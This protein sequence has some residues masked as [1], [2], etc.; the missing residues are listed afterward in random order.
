MVSDEERYAQVAR[1][2][3][4]VLN[5]LIVLSLKSQPIIDNF[6]VG[7]RLDWMQWIR[8]KKVIKAINQLC[9]LGSPVLAVCPVFAEKIRFVLPPILTSL[10]NFAFNWNSVAERCRSVPTMAHRQLPADLS[11]SDHSPKY[12]FISPI[13]SQ[14]KTIQL[15][16]HFRVAPPIIAKC[17]LC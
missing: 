3:S 15:F 1:S 6:M 8:P 2:Q 12:N 16:F 5:Q 10:L 9:F 13:L 4:G 17:Q 11:V 7:L 14:I